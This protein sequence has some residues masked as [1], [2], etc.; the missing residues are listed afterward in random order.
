MK[1]RSGTATR[2]GPRHSLHFLLLLLSTAISSSQ[3]IQISSVYSSGRQ[4]PDE[5]HLLLDVTAVDDLLE[6]QEAWPIVIESNTNNDFYLK[7]RPCGTSFL[8]LPIFS[9]KN[10]SEV[11]CCEE[12]VSLIVTSC[13]AKLL[14][15]GITWFCS[16][17]VLLLMML[18][19]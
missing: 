12:G 3:T 2:D 6:T 14:V 16:S 18:L 4:H 9:Q 15:A 13:L 7:I 10:F 11:S 8:G 1:Q 5:S 19:R 17:S